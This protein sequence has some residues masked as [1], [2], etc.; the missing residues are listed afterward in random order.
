MYSK[1][2]RNLLYFNSS[3]KPSVLVGE[4]CN[5][6]WDVKLANNVDGAAS[7]IDKYTPHVAIAQFDGLN[8][9]LASPVENLFRN[10]D[11]VEWVALLPKS[12]INKSHVKQII[13]ESFYDFH[14]LPP[15]PERLLATLGHAHGMASIKWGDAAIDLELPIGEDEMVGASPQMLE[16]FRNLRKVAG[17]DAPVLI[18][19]ESG[20]GKELAALAL[21]ERSSRRNMPFVAVN[22]GSL[23]SGLIQSELF[24]HEK[25]AFTGASQR[26]IGRI[27]SAAGGTIFLDEIGDLPLE[28]QVNLLRF[29]QEKTIERVGGTSQIKVDVRVLAAT[30]VDLEVAVAEGRF[31]EDLYYRL[32]VLKIKTPALRE[33]QGDVEVLAKYFFDKFAHEKRRNVKGFSPSALRIMNQYAW[34]GNVRELISRVRRAMVM[35]ERRL[36]TPEDLDLDRR[37]GKRLVTTLEAARNAAEIEAI[38]NALKKNNGN[39]SIAA[40]ALKVSRMTLYRLV[41]KYEL[42]FKQDSISDLI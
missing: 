29:L 35:C 1:E 8:D 33:R 16:L 3:D 27:E 38:R 28:L 31:R 39:M 10:I 26:K 25:G 32:N 7:I 24:G 2:N 5:A 40:Q 21:H 19:G 23:P 30:H 36:I 4:M 20:T 17:V 6:G 13:G 42:D 12:C 34:P 9:S 11:R 15:A 41:Q 37:D 14:T 18:T 22:C